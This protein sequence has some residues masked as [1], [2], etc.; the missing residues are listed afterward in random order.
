VNDLP[1]LTL[2]G[3]AVAVNP[4][5]VLERYAEAAGWSILQFKKRD[6]KK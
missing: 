4:D 5:K 2:V 1:L 3:H 6:L